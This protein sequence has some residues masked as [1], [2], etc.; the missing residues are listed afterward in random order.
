[1]P[2]PAS[3]QATIPLQ[4]SDMAWSSAN[5]RIYATANSDTG[6]IK[7]SLIVV[8][9]VTDIQYAGGLIYS[10]TASVFNPSTNVVQAP[11]G[12]QNSNPAGTSVTSSSFAVDASLDRA[13]FM[14]NDSP[15]TTNGQMTLEGFN[16]M[17]QPP[18]W[19]TR[20]PAANPLGGRTIRWGANG[21]A[22]VGGNAAS[23]N[24]TLISGSVISR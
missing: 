11:F 19:I 15:N 24:I 5:Q 16:L 8:N 23:P 1:M 10:S 22:F 9:P 7:G 13:Y 12:L 20:F 4:I 14:T 21:L 3:I 6:G 17:T 18:T 2:P